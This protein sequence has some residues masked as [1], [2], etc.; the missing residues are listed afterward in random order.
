MGK[1][2]F[3][4]FAAFLNM[5]R[6]LNCKHTIKIKKNE[7]NIHVN[8]CGSAVHVAAFRSKEP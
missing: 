8:G 7:K 4:K 3:C 6:Q 5:L 1:K 2:I